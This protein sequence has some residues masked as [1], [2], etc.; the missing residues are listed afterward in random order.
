[1][2]KGLTVEKVQVALEEANGSVAEAARI[3]GVS[4]VTV[5]DWIHRHGIVR[6]IKPR[7]AA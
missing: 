4:R 5:Y 2:S 3:L 7:Q 1:M 6:V